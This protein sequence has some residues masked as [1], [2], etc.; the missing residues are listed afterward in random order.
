MIFFRF[1]IHTIRQ[2]GF[3]IILIQDTLMLI[4]L[5]KQRSTKPFPF[6]NVLI[7]N[8]SNILYT[9]TYHKSIY[10][11]LLLNFDN[12]TSRFYKI[13]LT[14]CLVDRAYKIETTLASFHNDVTKIKESLKRNAIPPFLIDKI[15]KSHLN[16]VH[17][18]SDQ[19]NPG[20]DKTRFYKL[21]YIGK[22]SEQA[23]KKLSKIYKQR[24]R[25]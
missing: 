25:S 12:F 15:T 1:S 8:R 5:W 14:K 16:K 22:Y 4:L 17:S 7:D 9:S 20:S 19:S 11:G 18:N 6:W 21:P 3:S 23:Q 2:N 13:S 10:S 24:C